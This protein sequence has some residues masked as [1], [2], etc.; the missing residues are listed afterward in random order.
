MNMTLT[1]KSTLF[2]LVLGIAILLF[3][4]FKSCQPRVSVPSY[5]QSYVDSLND[6]NNSL[7]DEICDLHGDISALDSVLLFRKDKVI[8]GRETI[9][10]LEKTVT[11]TDTIVITYVDA[12]NNQIK[13]LDTIVD[14]Q[15]KKIDKQAKI[16]DKQDT[17]IVNTNK[18]V[19][20]QEKE[21]EDI[22]KVVQIKDK[23]IK[24][25]KFERWLYPIIGIAAT[26]LIL[27]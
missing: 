17:I 2:I 13:E 9:K 10:Y 4:Q 11:I 21:L 20:I 26:V 1:Y 14:I 23:K 22:Q 25:L 27:K 15:D 16:I 12:L 7:V 19:A 6:E 18:I 5:S 8:K 3:L 24:I